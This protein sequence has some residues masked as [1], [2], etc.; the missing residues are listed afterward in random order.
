M[1]R[2]SIDTDELRQ[3]SQGM[4][5]ESAGL[6]E[7]AVALRR[8]WSQLGPVP[9][10]VAPLQARAELLLDRLRVLG[11]TV[12]GAA[13][14][15]DHEASLRE[16]EQAMGALL[17]LFLGGA[18][19]MLA[20]MV[21][22]PVFNAG[23]P[24]P[25]GRLPLA[26][27][28]AGMGSGL[29]TGL[30]P[31]LAG[32][33]PAGGGRADDLGSAVA[34]ANH[35][36]ANGVS[37]HPALAE[38]GAGQIQAEVNNQFAFLNQLGLAPGWQ[39]APVDTG[40]PFLGAAGVVN[41]GISDLLPGGSVTSFINQE[42][43]FVRQLAGRHGFSTPFGIPSFEASLAKVIGPGGNVQLAN[44]MPLVTLGQ[45]VEGGLFSSILGPLRS[46]L[47]PNGRLI[48]NAGIFG[49]ELAGLSGQQFQS[50]TGGIGSTNV[51]STFFTN[52]APF[53]I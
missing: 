13:V 25:A 32:I 7:I 10:E 31:L 26:V 42:N 23:P 35:V 24:A 5:T 17:R 15:L 45:G 46:Q 40:L 6:A 41:P 33:L 3:L 14:S 48:P 34:F 36:I 27:S 21:G 29:A 18:H 53:L 38:I 9:G 4:R 2:I 30:P 16:V 44:G 39:G 1:S 50:F 49:P 28:L 11:A 20:P 51:V 8:A 19:W 12:E 47:Y 43:D 22:W 52:Q 37:S